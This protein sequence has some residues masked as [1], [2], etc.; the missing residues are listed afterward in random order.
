MDS[1]VLEQ[2][3]YERIDRLCSEAEKAF[4]PKY[5][6]ALPNFNESE[7][8]V[9]L[10]QLRPSLRSRCIFS[11]S[12]PSYLAADLQLLRDDLDAF[13]REEREDESLR[14]LAPLE[15]K[16]YESLLIDR[17]RR[18]SALHSIGVTPGDIK[19]DHFRLSNNDFHDIPLFDFSHSYTF[20][21][22]RPSMVQ[23]CPI[24]SRFAHRRSAFRSMQKLV[25]MERSRVRGLILTRYAFAPLLLEA[26][27]NES[28][29][30]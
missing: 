24:Y 26:L 12:V 27:L 4:F 2:Q 29:V 17:L 22:Q 30:F 1:F 21:P 9:V 25:H 16:W 20:T 19:E 5:Y 3:A 15:R 18:L 28:S 11:N 6:G 10:E 23:T 14:C 7:N 8:I 13:E